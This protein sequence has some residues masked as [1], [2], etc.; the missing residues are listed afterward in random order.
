MGK[1][2]LMGPPAVR[3]AV[4]GLLGVLGL[5]ASL[6]SAQALAA[7]VVEVRFVAP[8]RFIDAE[9]SPA[10][11]ERVLKQIA[12]HF[13]EEAGKRLG[14]TQKLLIEVQDLN[15]AGEIEPVGRMQERVRVLRGVGWPSM[16]LHFVLSEDGQ[17]AR[18][19]QARLSD[20]SYLQ[21]FPRYPDS[22][23]LRYEKRM[24]DVWLDKEFPAVSAQETK[25]R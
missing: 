7:G 19:G 10:D 22:V 23:S 5:T 2:K 3:C 21:S 6:V 4:S 1:Q 12:A 17:R 15:L 11:R 14:S 18:E 20:M 24:I 13:S 16:S 25:P 8:E 9:E